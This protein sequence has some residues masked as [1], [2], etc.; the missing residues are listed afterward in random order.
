MPKQISQLL[1]ELQAHAG[2]SLE[3]LT[4]KEDSRFQEFS[5]RWTN[6]GR[7][8][9]AAIVLPDTEE[10]IQQTVITFHPTSFR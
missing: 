8:I 3:I 4:Q 9:P 6:I 10:Q 7:E 1:A 2:P 5:K